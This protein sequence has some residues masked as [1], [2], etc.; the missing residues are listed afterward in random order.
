MLPSTDC[1]VLRHGTNEKIRRLAQEIIV[2]AAAGDRGAALHAQLVSGG[3]REVIADK[4]LR[5]IQTMGDPSAYRGSTNEEYGTKWF[6]ETP[7][8]NTAQWDHGFDDGARFKHGNIG[9]G[10]YVD[11]ARDFCA[12]YFSLASNDEKIAGIDHSPGYLRA[13]AKMLAGK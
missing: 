8:R 2:H 1:T 5:A 12:M 11:P 3:E 7:E 6:G 4:R 10:I 9:Q 13:A